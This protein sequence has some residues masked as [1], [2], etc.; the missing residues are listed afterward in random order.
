MARFRPLTDPAAHPSVRG[1]RSDPLHRL[2]PGLGHHRRGAQGRRRYPHLPHPVT[3]K[4]RHTRWAPTACPAEA[5]AEPTARGREFSGGSMRGGIE[6]ASSEPAPLRCR[7]NEPVAYDG[8]G[9]VGRCAATCGEVEGVE[10]RDFGV[11]ELDDAA[12]RQGRFGEVAR[13]DGD[14]CSRLDG[15]QD[16]AEVGDDESYGADDLREVLGSAG[17]GLQDGIGRTRARLRVLTGD[18]V[19]VHDDGHRAATVLPARRP[20]SAGGRGRRPAP[21]R[22]SGRGRREGRSRRSRPPSPRTGR[23]VPRAPPRCLRGRCGTPR[24]RPR[25]RRPAH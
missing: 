16:R 18:Q 17:E 5:E 23:A 21:G 12:R 10:R 20:R 19:A 8:G 2:R 1:R 14:A 15:D 11:V 7:L 22:P 9:R 13:Q 3:G 4:N 25:R 24:R 6:P